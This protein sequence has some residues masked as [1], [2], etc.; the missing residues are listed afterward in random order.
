[1]KRE[2]SS[3]IVQG[4]YLVLNFDFTV[5]FNKLDNNKLLI[6]F[7]FKLKYGFKFLL[8]QKNKNKNHFIELWKS[9]K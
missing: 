5:L 2:Y 8:S 3:Y 6:F 9:K 4:R 1:M 7:F